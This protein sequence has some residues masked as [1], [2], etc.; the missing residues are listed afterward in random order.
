VTNRRYDSGEITLGRL[1]GIG[2]VVFFAC[3]LFLFIDTRHRVSGYQITN[4][5]GISG[6]VSVTQ[7]ESQR[8]GTLCTGDFVSADGTV[9]RH[10]IRVNG[11]S[12]QLRQGMPAAVSDV[13]ATEAWT[14]D[15][16]PWLAVSPVQLAALAPVVLILALVWGTV[17]AGPL[18]WRYHGYSLRSRYARDR[19]LVRARAARMGRVH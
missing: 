6:T 11:A 15:G 9:R 12:D 7:C 2:S 3:L 17:R 19:A 16:H 1:I 18:S 14:T 5:H 13:N 8:L 10:D 4:G